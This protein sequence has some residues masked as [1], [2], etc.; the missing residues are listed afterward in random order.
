M[1]LNIWGFL[2]SLLNR[3]DIESCQCAHAHAAHQH[4]RSGAQCVQC[5]CDQYRAQSAR[6]PIGQRWAYA[7]RPTTGASGALS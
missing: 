5:G 4:H 6:E 7:V 1:T 3:S 2:T